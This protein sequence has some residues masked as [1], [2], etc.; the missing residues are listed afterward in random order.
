MN[1]Q[2][3][4][5]A[6]ML[7]A[8]ATASAQVASHAP[9]VFRQQSPN[10]SAAA[11]NPP[12]SKIVVRINDSV[13][14]ESDLL[15]EEYTIFPYARQ[16]N[17]IPKDLA[18]QI[19]DGAMKMMIFEELVYQD[20]LRQ[21]MTVPA[22]RMQR[23]EIDFR[24]QFPSPEVYDAFVKSEFHGSHALLIA[25]IRRSLL[26]DK[27][28]QDRIESRS[29][30]SVAD[31]RAFYEKNPARF[32]HPETFTFQTISILPPANATAEQLKEGRTRAES[33]LKQAKAA[34]TSE[35]FGLL[36]EKISDDDY[37]VMM[38]QHKP[39]PVDQLAPQVVA[40]L[41]GMKPGDVSDLIQIEQAYTIVHLQVHAMAGETRF[42][43]V[44]TQLMKDLHQR[45]ENQLR[46]DLDQK[47]QKSAKIEVM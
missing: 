18:P 45:K 16:H 14:T 22:S 33:A 40:A 46:S 1:H 42:E 29:A 39:V 24:K 19:R 35:Q 27:Y 47:L 11:A 36:A 8:F 3:P 41:K 28:L 13:L 9:T 12:L 4:V 2:T 5:L 38:G 7:L 21:H 15:R 31:A 37:R 26:I 30:I 32:T 25:K 17:G 20:A 44:K 34:K 10:T 6:A 23:A 43:E